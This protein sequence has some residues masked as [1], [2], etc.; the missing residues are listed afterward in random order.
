MLDR[1]QTIATNLAPRLI[2]IRRHLHAHPELSGQEYQTSAYVAGVLSS[3]GL[4]VRESVGKTGVV[5]ELPGKNPSGCLAI[6]TDMDALPI[7]EHTDLEFTSRHQGVMHACGH[8]VHTTV[9]LGTAM[10]LSQLDGA[11]PGSVR[12]LFQ[13]AEEIAKGARWMVDDGAMDDVKAVLG[14]HVFPSIPGGS[15]GIRYGAL[16]AAA[17]DLEITITG[18]SGHGARP[19]EAID[20]IWIAAQVITTL[21][22]AIGRTQNPLRPVVLTIG[23]ITG[24]R[25]PNVIADNVKLVGTV[26]SLHPETHAQLPAWI[27]NIVAGVCRSYGAG[28]EVNYRRVVPSVQN[29]PQLTQLLESAVQEAWGSDR[30]QILMEPSLGAEDFSVYLDRAPGVMFRLGVGRANA[31]NYP[32]HHPKFEV[33]ESAILT[34]VV[35]LAYATYKYFAAV[36]LDRISSPSA[37]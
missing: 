5:G 19:H 28:Y 6:R 16:T 23:Q 13:P 14:L 37:V 8:D 3:S 12:F 30:V 15:V 7:Q 24:G 29:D 2:E 10:V 18:E 9:G 36:G 31:H 35:T 21:Q 27:E 1:I 26:R 32:L 22:Q 20:A 25:A 33:D 11:L 4:H 34:G 17:D